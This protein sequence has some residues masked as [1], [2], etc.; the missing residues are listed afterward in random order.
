MNLRAAGES[1][2]RQNEQE[3]ILLPEHRR[4]TDTLLSADDKLLVKTELMTF[5]ETMGSLQ[6]QAKLSKPAN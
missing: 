4:C 6:V 5:H 1:C 2:S 3:V